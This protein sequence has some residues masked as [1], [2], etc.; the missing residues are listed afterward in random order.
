MSTSHVENRLCIDF[1]GIMGINLT[2]SGT[3]G[4][5]TLASVKAANSA[6]QST[7]LQSQ[8]V[9]HRAVEV[10]RV[11]E[12]A[13]RRISN[14]NPEEVG[15]ADAPHRYVGGLSHVAPDTDLH[16]SELGLSGGADG[17]YLMVEDRASGSPARPWLRT[18]PA[19]ARVEP[20]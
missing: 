16:R 15:R 19:L 13:L 14:L 4:L 20:A 5:V 9:A 12:E 17:K 11:L 18:G 7:H 1:S 6:S 2:E 8:Y 10:S 3:K